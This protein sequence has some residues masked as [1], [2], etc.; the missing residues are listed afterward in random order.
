MELYS[1]V[2][3]IHSWLRWAVL[4]TMVAGVGLCA[5]GLVARRPVD[6]RDRAVLGAMM[7][8][9]H[10]QVVLGLLMQ[11]GLS[12]TVRLAYGDMKAA[13]KAP[14]LRFWAVEHLAGMLLAAVVVTVG[15]VVGKRRGEVD[16]E[17]AGDPEEVLAASA[18]RFKT[19]LVA[20]ALGLL[21]IIGS[22]PWPFRA[23]VARDLFRGLGF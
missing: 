16:E 18:K 9:L 11:V 7:G 20:L 17:A 19:T 5:Q 12:P 22:I 14:M 8:S 1:I 4:L 6:K 21:I 2:L 10:L 13:M 23:A 15:V 3:V